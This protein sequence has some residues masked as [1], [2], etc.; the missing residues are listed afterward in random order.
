MTAVR[1]IEGFNYPT[2]VVETLPSDAMR[3]EIDVKTD[4]GTILNSLNVR[5]IPELRFVMAPEPVLGAY[6]RIAR[7]TRT[8]IGNNLK[9]SRTLATLRELLLPKL[10]SGEV[11]VNVPKPLDDQ[12]RTTLIETHQ[13]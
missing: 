8:Q 12:E 10:I 3:W 5:S 9:A 6:E 4:S 11:R 13:A 1:C 7:P 2:F